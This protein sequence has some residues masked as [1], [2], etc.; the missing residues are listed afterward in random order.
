MIKQLTILTFTILLLSASVSSAQTK[1]EKTLVKSFNLQ[2]K[3][4]VL[5]DLDGEVQI[6][7]WDNKIMRVQMEVSLEGGTST[8]LKSLVQVGRYNLKSEFGEDFIKI[9]APALRK[10]IRIR[11]KLLK[12][13]IVYTIFAP[14][15][16]M[17]KMADEATTSL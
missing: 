13:N 4:T 2:G 15:N 1:T 11:G 17:V 14:E 7:S 6:K 16:V 8:M 12:E 5:L 10:E 9:F 3:Q